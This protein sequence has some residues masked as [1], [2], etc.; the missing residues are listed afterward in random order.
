MTGQ[1]GNH[2]NKESQQSQ[3]GGNEGQHGGRGFAG[4]DPK[5][6]REIAA[7]GGRASHSHTGQQGSS[8]SG[9]QSMQEG[10]SRGQQGGGGH[11]SKQQSQDDDSRGQQGGGRGFAGMDPERQ[12]EIASE[13]GKAAHA[14][15]HAH[16]FDS[17]EAREAGSHSHDGDR[18]GKRR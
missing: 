6:Q 5:R 7:E 1:Q 14:S 10:E 8:A 17:R 18:E 13:G 3:Q 9:R 4:M 12:R 2:K 11:G 15:G 16:E